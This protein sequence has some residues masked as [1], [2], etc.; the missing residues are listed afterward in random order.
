MRIALIV[1]YSSGPMRGNIATVSRIAE[2][3]MASG[4]EV[5]CFPLDALRS[6]GVDERVRDYAP[7]IVHCFHAGLCGETACRSAGL[8]GAPC[9]ITITGSDIYDPRYRTA[10]PTARAVERADALVCFH[11]LVAEEVAKVFPGCRDRIRIIPQGVA[12]I[13]LT[14]DP[15]P[16]FP[17]TFTMLLPA[18]LRPV[19]N[20]LF[21]LRTLAPLVR[22]IP[23][24]HLAVAGGVIDRAYA[25]EVRHELEK[26]PFAEWLGEVPRHMMGNL[27]VATDLVLNCS[28]FESSP[29]TL[30]EAM[31]MGCGV[32]AADIPGNRAVIRDGETGWLY[33][34]EKQFTSLVKE[35]SQ[36]R[37][38]V[39]KAGE[40][41]RQEALTRFS[42]RQ[43]I[44]RYL[45]LFGMLVGKNLNGRPKS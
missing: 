4:A 25:A 11:E 21:P 17:G 24:L 34:S 40:R 36:K 7:R 26:A 30:L 45:E 5:A 2:G 39:N 12:P 44:S 6:E 23:G 29:N 43:E 13:P 31:A 14:P 37:E 8:S 20:V 16:A 3:L 42:C 15:W 9:V 1:P 27:Y 22:G 28:T 32:L 18:A 10:A 19:K 35:L 33:R 38:L 41:A